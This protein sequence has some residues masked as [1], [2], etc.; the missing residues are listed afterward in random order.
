MP[1]MDASAIRESKTEL[2]FL[3]V[4]NEAIGKGLCKEYSGDAYD[5]IFS[6]R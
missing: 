4:R 6:P 1:T 3:L 5:V 2:R